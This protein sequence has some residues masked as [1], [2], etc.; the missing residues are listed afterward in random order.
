MIQIN[1]Y[2]KS[3][4]RTQKLGD[5]VFPH[6]SDFIMFFAHGNVGAQP[7]FMAYEPLIKW[8]MKAPVN[9]QL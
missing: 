5:C 3:S 4:N 1:L 6:V 2:F 8:R 9:K 7:R